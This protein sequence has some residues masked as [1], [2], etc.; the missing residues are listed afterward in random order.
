MAMA[1]RDH[2]ITTMDQLQALYG[3]TLLTSIVKA[4]AIAS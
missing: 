1:Y 2:L 3:E 4:T